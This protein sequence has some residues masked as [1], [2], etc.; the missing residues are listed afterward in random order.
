MLSCCDIERP[1]QAAIIGHVR[2]GTWRA[3]RRTGLPGPP[4]P[5]QAF[6]TQLKTIAV[7]AVETITGSESWLKSKPA[8]GLA[9]QRRYAK[10]K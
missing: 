8:T 9:F 2:N 6:V 10:D 4:P 1:D 3:W 5:A 7:A